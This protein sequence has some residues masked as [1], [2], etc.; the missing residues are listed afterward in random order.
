MIRLYVDPQISG[1]VGGHPDS[2]SYDDH[3]T[4]EIGNQVE[5]S[6]GGWES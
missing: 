4:D 5:G 1:S 3:P 2:Q 6:K